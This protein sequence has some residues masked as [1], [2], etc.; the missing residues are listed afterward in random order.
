M[1]SLEKNEIN[2]HSFHSYIVW[3]KGK[4]N[5][6][7]G[8]SWRIVEALLRSNLWTQ[9]WW[10]GPHNMN[11]IASFLSLWTKLTNFFFPWKG[12]LEEIGTCSWLQY[13]T[14]F[15]CFRIYELR[16]K[17]RISVAAASKLLANMVYNYKGMGLSMV[18]ALPWFTNFSH[19]LR[20]VDTSPQMLD[21]VFIMLGNFILSFLN[22]VPNRL[23]SIS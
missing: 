9:M 13:R 4:Y 10:T 6:N 22:E 8:Y 5:L 23:G 1:K 11:P 15:V 2:A 17:E 21:S 3:K 12:V 19:F 7:Q 16:N 20:S 14:L 18:R